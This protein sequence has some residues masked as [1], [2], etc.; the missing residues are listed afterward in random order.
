[1]IEPVLLPL[2]G[3][4]FSQRSVN[5]ATAA[6]LDISSINFWQPL[7]RSFFDIRVLH[8]GSPSY[9]NTDIERIYKNHEQEKKR[10]YNERIID[11]ERATFTPLVFS[12]F[13]GM[14]QEAVTFVKNLSSKLS[15]TMNQSYADTIS[16]VRSRLRFDLL[17]TCIIALRGH[18]GRYYERPADIENLDINLL[19]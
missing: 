2:S 19:D 5:T 4:T 15:E 9:A 6:R 11:I 17:K 10:T 16:Y 13:G 3:E 12:T 1:M 8:P 14:G 18:R 7:G